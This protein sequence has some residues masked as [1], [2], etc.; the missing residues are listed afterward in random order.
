VIAAALTA[1][2]LAPGASAW[3]P[4]A[5]TYGVGTQSGDAITMSDG[6]VL[7]ANV[8]YPTDPKTGQEAAGT[9]PVILTQTPYGKD[10]GKYVGGQ[11]GGLAGNS[12]YLVQR[13]Y[14]NVVAD[15]RGTGGS[16]GEW[17]L[18]D[19]VQGTDGATLVSWAAKLP[20]ADGDVGLLGA[21]Y[22]GINQFETAATAGSAHV[23]AMFPIIAANDLY[24]DTSFAG[25]FPDIEFDS[26]YLG[27]TGGLNL[28]G[29]LEEGNSDVFTALTD[30]VHDLA[31]FDAA[32]VANVE[33]GGDEAHDQSYWAARNPVND[34]AKIV[35]DGI[36]AFLIGGWYDLFQRGEMLN[37][38]SFQ[39]AYD[40]L[41]V[42]GPMSPTQPVTPRYQLLMG[43]WYHVTTGTSLQYH[44]LDMNGL[45]LAWFDHWLKG[46]D[47]GITDTTTPLHLQDLA[48]GTYM[49]ASRYPLDQAT[50]TTYYL[51]AGST[52]TTTAPPKSSPTD[53]L[54]FTGTEIPCS[55][56]TEQWAAGAGVL[57]LSFF[58]IKDPCTQDASLSQ[59]GPGTQNYATAPFRKPTTLAGPVAATVY[60]TS[61]TS[62][63]EFVVQL[64]DVSP[65][66]AATPL[67]SGLLEGDQRAVDAS[68][69]WYAPDG[70]P[71]LPYHRYTQPAQTPV[72]P[73]AVTRYD[74]E[75]F[76]TNVTL[77]PGHRLRVTIATSDFPHALPSI[78]QA[79]NLLGGIYALEHSAA[80]PS[81]IELPL[82]TAAPG[83][84]GGLV[85]AA[86]MPLGCPRATG[87]LHGVTLGP[88]R[89]GM[90]RA[91][92][93]TAF[94]SSSTQGRPYM[95]FFCLSPVGI[96]V[97]YASARLQRSVSPA[98][99]RRVRGTVVMALTANTHYALRG[100][101]AGALLRTV[102]ARLHVGRGYAVGLNTWY[103]VWNG[104]SRGVLMVRNGVVLEIGI[105]DLLLTQNRSASLRFLKSFY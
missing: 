80:Y 48:T 66:G 41:P 88:V 5:A 59:L 78:V 39:N 38:S 101:R 13:G 12:D 17:G 18:F 35:N 32:Q 76:P 104:R 8:Y 97:G 47:T 86:R 70:R 15:V 72:V 10:D 53:T 68:R 102:A 71:L 90:T 89:L 36:P 21:S 46:V 96:R 20:H 63:T 42:L 94:V 79:P 100:V 37:Y 31:D 44:G 6:A 75:V 92:A 99:R 3:Q 83:S 45:E 19:P 2:A 95:D 85:A 4:E 98:A 52:L 23:K 16:Q 69:S 9:F 34:I 22:L 49:D 29:P 30:H 73:G 26:F 103:L 1:A 87:T 28:L 33:A 57:A 81:S 58:G 7:R 51:G 43:P 64:S 91:R 25:G 62:D 11:L 77:E 56:S 50:P 27:L 65:S 40:H 55:T 67:T 82:I 54:V 61:T 60:A 24:R 93:R 74:I 14:I 84:R 105:A